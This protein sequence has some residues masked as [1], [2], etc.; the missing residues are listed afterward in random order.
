MN[1]NKQS[2]N[3]NSPEVNKNNYIINELGKENY[4]LK[5]K[6]KKLQSLNM[7]ISV[8]NEEL[9]KLKNVLIKKEKECLALQG[10]IT[11]KEK[12]MDKLKNIIIIDRK[13]YNKDLR[14]KELDFDNEKLQI[15]RD[16]DILKKIENFNKIN[17]LN[18]ILYSQVLNLEKTIEEIKKEE[19]IK[20]KDKEMEYNN[21]IDKYKKKL[22]DFLKKA[23]KSK[24]GDDQLEMNNKMNMLHIQEL[25]N[26]IEYQN[27]EV[28]DLLKE[29]KN[30]KIK[31]INLSND[32]N[33]YKIMVNILTHKN[34]EFQQ[35]LKSAYKPIREKLTQKHNTQKMI[36]KTENNINKEIIDKK[37]KIYSPIS[38]K[39]KI[40]LGFELPKNNQNNKSNKNLYIYNTVSNNG[41][42]KKYKL[43][44]VSSISS[45]FKQN[46]LF[47]EKK[48]K[49]KYKD[50]YEFY[51]K[52]Y[53]LIIEKFKNIFE[54]YNNTL[55]KIYNEEIKDKNNDISININDFKDIK[56]ENMSPEQKYSI[57]IKLINHIAPLICKKDF[58]ENSFRDKVFKVKQKYNIFPIK[59]KKLFFGGQKSFEI[60]KKIKFKEIK[61][62]KTLRG[63]TVST[64]FSP[65]NKNSE[66]KKILGFSN[67]LKF[68]NSN[69]SQSL[70]IPRFEYKNTDI[71]DSPF[72]HY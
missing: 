19:E 9:K 46:E 54:I 70:K 57:L 6:V 50:L 63:C 1:V 45:K 21:K 33:I 43:N 59:N 55:E 53:S 28:N 23:M 22:I 68:S 56:F 29:R 49:E 71:H 24:K 38:R 4:E 31:I 52:K 64:N 18:D 67:L 51:K 60:N 36:S 48:E 2:N 30:L 42:S 7:S 65:E 62:P 69:I 15:K 61:S 27:K 26:E 14:L 47:N 17:N 39:K 13:N 34:E 5:E 10:I 16:H 20:L 37:F 11:E 8:Q 44:R 72:A 66:E 3:N 40:M 35:K 32:L 25:I 58:E 12:D 41:S